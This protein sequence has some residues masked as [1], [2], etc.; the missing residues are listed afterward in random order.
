MSKLS[1]CSKESS[2]LPDG[3]DLERFKI[4]FKNEFTE[5]FYWNIFNLKFIY[6]YFILKAL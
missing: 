1:F 5:S 3:Y 4:R 6:F 2:F